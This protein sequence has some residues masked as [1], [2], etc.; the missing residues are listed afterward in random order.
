M[1]RKYVKIFPN[2]QGGT[3]ITVDGVDV[4]GYVNHSGIAVEFDR[5]VAHVWLP[6]A[7]VQFA[8]EFPEA[9]VNALSGD[10]ER[11]V[12]RAAVVAWAGRLHGA[13]VAGDWL[14]VTE[15]VRDMRAAA[16]A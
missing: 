16:R 3:T 5:G 6:V 4:S 13:W 1:T 10:E 12:P 11:P 2:D 14:Q 15:V 8:G 9:V 7:P